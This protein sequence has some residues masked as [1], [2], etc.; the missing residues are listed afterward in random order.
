MQ[1]GSLSM[2]IELVPL[3]F[4]STTNTTNKMTTTLPYIAKNK[5]SINKHK[6]VTAVDFEK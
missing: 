5:K 2:M 3:S 6:K 1:T 4:P